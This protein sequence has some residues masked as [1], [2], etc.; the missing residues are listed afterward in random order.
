MLTDIIKL[1]QPIVNATNTLNIL[2]HVTILFT[3][4]SLFFRYYIR[5]VAADAINGEISDI[6][7]NVVH[8]SAMKKNE[9]KE[10][11]HKKIYEHFNNDSYVFDQ[12][13]L[14]DLVHNITQTNNNAKKLYN[15]INTPNNNI[16]QISETMNSA[17]ELNDNIKEV[18]N[19]ANEIKDN[20]NVK[21]IFEKVNEVKDN[22]N[23][24]Q[25]LDTANK[26]KDTNNVKQINDKVK[27]IKDKVTDNFSYDYYVN[28][29]SKEDDKRAKINNQILF[30]MNTTN[31]LIVIM[32]ILFTYY[33]IKT[34]S[35]NVEEVKYL[36]FENMLTFIFIGVIEYLF[37]TRVA[38]NFIPAPP[39]L[40]AKSFINA[41][42]ND[43]N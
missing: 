24:N 34:K 18:I 27:E 36:L 21:Q 13:N 26:L 28:L 43:F 29:F 35:V 33:L 40:I 4:L 42:K 23:I 5:F 20:I 6:V 32:L 17:N 22:I 25:I 19:T 1:K 15:N 14:E 16:K 41:L 8:K 12:N 30:Y 3:V 38:L 10:A 11:I 37:F 7:E 31:I 9:I 2:I 39:S